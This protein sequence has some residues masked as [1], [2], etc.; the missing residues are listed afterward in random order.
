[1][2]IK[3]LTLNCFLVLLTC[4]ML[5]SSCSSKLKSYPSLVNQG[6]LPVS[7]SNSYLGT[8]LFLGSEAAK[9]RILYQ[10]LKGRGAPGAI[11]IIEENFKPAYMLLFY[12]RQTQFY[13]A[14]L[15]ASKDSYEWILRGPY[16]IE[17]NDFRKLVNI[18]Q[19]NYEGSPLIVDGKT[20]VFVKPTPTPT[21]TATTRPTLQPTPLKKK[22]KAVIIKSTGT[23]EKPLIPTPTPKPFTG[24][25]SGPG[26]NSDQQAIRLSKGLT[27][28]TADG[29]V[30]HRVGSSGETLEAIAKWYTGDT[31]QAKTIAEY[32][33]LAAGSELPKGAKIKIPKA[34]VKTEQALH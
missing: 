9:S 26:L 31:A 25:P 19:T 5:F 14:E 13:R 10:F 15:S 30:L 8:N 16:N 6:I 22:T 2:K 29:D 3:I 27:E 11:E 4:G 32:N 24:I 17:R 34:I 33:S 7:P 18:E 20:E 1:M 23:E 28:L 21:A 12:P